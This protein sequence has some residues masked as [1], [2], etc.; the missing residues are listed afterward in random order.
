MLQ[1]QDYYGESEVTLP[2][3][4][5]TRHFIF[6]KLH[7]GVHLQGTEG[8]QNKVSRSGAA[9]KDPSEFLPFVFTLI[10]KSDLMTLLLARERYRRVH[11]VHA[12]RVFGNR[13]NQRQIRCKQR[14]TQPESCC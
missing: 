9:I 4:G 2:N 12:E 7:A 5:V 13:S 1:I 14:R 11:A 10:R 3:E 8:Y 6:F